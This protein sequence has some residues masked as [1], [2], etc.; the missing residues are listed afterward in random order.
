MSEADRVLVITSCT[1]QKKSSA[2]LTLDDFLRGGEHL[3]TKQ[4]DLAAASCSAETMYTG[5]QH[6]RLLHGVTAYRAAGGAVDLRILSAGYGFLRG[7]DQIV[8][9]EAT[10]KALSRKQAR[11]WTETQ[12][13]PQTFRDLM[14]EASLLTCVA[15]GDDYLRACDLQQDMVF[16]SPTLLLCGERAAATL[17]DLPNLFVV[18]LT[19]AD[20]KR[21]RC[22]LLGLKGELFARILR[23]LAADEPLRLDSADVLLADLAQM[24][25][26]PVAKVGVRPV[27]RPNPAL[28]YV[29]PIPAKAPPAFSYFIPDWD[30]LVDPA[31]DFATDTHAGGSGDWSNEVYA[32]QLYPRP[33]YDGILVSKVVAEKGAKKMARMN[34]L[35]VHRFL[36]V[37]DTFPVMGDCGAFGYIK[38]TAPPYTTAD[39]LE[40]Y[41]RLGFDYGVSLDH[42]IVKATEEEKQFRYDLTIHNA[43]QFLREHHRQGLKWIPMGAVQGWSPASYAEAA[44]QTAAMGYTYIALGGLVRMQTREILR[45]LEQVREVVPA[46]VRIHLFGIGRLAPVADFRR[47][48]VT[49]VDS[50]SPL[51][52]AWL[53]AGQNY[54]ACDGSTYSAVRIPQAAKGF[55]AKRMVS[56]GRAT[57]AQVLRLEQVCLRAMHDLD[58]DRI[59]VDAALEP[60]LEYD[61][62]VTEGARQIGPLLRRTLEARPW[63]TCE[64]PIC[65]KAGVD[66]IIFRGNNRNRRRG[67]HN[68]HI[69]YNRLQQILQGTLDMTDDVFTVDADE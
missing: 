66:V 50:S 12:R 37:P 16:T 36:R 42:L 9:Y 35:G 14:Q 28:D 19:N 26:A 47:L 4:A 27:A 3:R 52:K 62:L 13:V 20:A 46:H 39:V 18:S 17:P 23:K 59:S 21:F 10:Y 24:T 44:R 1:G 30:D 69:F 11:T 6:T 64:C 56:E 32:H 57:E 33:S 61:A 65:V 5:E 22:S 7:H 51:R 29:V 49:S 60:L 67:F 15:L 53:S 34:T 45:M 38:E 48:G 25:I 31:Y 2:G 41:T 63:K 54:L 68:T 40:Y 58:A 43:E 55:R 8:P